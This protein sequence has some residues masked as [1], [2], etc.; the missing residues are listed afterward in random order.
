MSR[1]LVVAAHPDDEVL[2]CGG[3]LARHVEAGDSVAVMFLTDGVGARG[4]SPEAEPAR[5]AREAS[6]RAA[7]SILGV[8]EIVFGNLPD[9]QIDSVPLLR[10]AQAVEAVA[11]ERQPDLVY[12]HHIGDL[13]VDHRLAHQAVLTAFRPQPGQARPTILAFE[14][15]SSTE[16]QSV[17]AGLAFQPNWFEPIEGQLERKLDS[18]KA[19]GQEM[20]PWPHARSLTAVEHLARW[21]GAT[22]GCAAAEAFM[23][24]RRIG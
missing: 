21:R 18:L 5:R 24:V 10:V 8:C 11:R 3:T 1:V 23:L 17:A 20:R 7:L 4:N 22:I 12:T 13:N 6:A 16:W 14:T 9:N 2:G 19:Y 15:A